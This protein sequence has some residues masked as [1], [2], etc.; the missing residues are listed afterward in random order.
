MVVDISQ[1]GDHRKT[2]RK[3]GSMKSVEKQICQEGVPIYK[4]E[5]KQDLDEIYKCPFICLE[6]QALF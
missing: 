6:Q 3:S 4:R 2:N 1:L 5:H